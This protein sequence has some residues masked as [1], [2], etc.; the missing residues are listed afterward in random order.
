MNTKWEEIREVWQQNEQ[1]ETMSVSAEVMSYV[2]KGA[3]KLD[4]EVSRRKRT[5]WLG[6]LLVIGVAAAVYATANNALQVAGAILLG[7]AAVFGGGYLWF[8]D[9]PAPQ[10]DPAT[11]LSAYRAALVAKFDRQ[12]QLL[13]QAKYWLVTPIFL[14]LITWQVGELLEAIEKGKDRLWLDGVFVVLLTAFFGW[15]AWRNEVKGVRKLQRHREE[16]LREFDTGE[17]PAKPPRTYPL[18]LDSEDR[19]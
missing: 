2:E 12:I 11:S 13:R 15:I 19:K 9:R 14:G 6:C 16:L 18:G 8:S 3:G 4:T 17:T 7:A 5:E 1:E 10:P